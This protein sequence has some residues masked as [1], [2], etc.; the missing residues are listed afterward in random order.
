M[1]S[2]RSFV[3]T[4][5]LLASACSTTRFQS[6]WRDPEARPLRLTG[7]QVVAAFVG[8]NESTRRAAEEA[9]AREIT[10]RGARGVPSYTVL[11]AG[12]LRDRER[13]KEKLERLGFDGAVVMRVVGSETQVS[14]QPGYW[15]RPYYRTFWGYWGWGWGR[16]AEPG[17][18]R[19]D[20]IVSVETLVY[21][22]RQDRLVWAGISR[23]VDP[24]RIDSFVS[25]LA[26]GVSR[27]LEKEGL[28]RG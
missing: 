11:D 5:A 21:S 24:A 20:R 3:V 12:E 8:R 6:T 27:Q 2:A 16:V 15:N 22:L 23:T 7:A 26:N 4:A 14:Y 1:R 25:E 10:A 28:L 18:L 19:A 9:M 13:A 17:Y